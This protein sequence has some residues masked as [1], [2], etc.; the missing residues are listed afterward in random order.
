MERDRLPLSSNY[1]YGVNKG[2]KGREQA[3]GSYQEI[4]NKLH[5]NMTYK[6]VTMVH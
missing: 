6:F 4:L 3:E 2:N 5:L 1:D